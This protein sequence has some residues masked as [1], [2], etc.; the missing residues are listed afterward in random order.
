M[1]LKTGKILTVGSMVLSIAFAFIALVGYEETDPLRM[2]FGGAAM[3]LMVLALVFLFTLCRCP[4]CGHRLT[5]GMLTLKV[6][7]NCKRDLETGLKEKPQNVQQ[8][9]KKKKKR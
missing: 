1:E 4:W 3:L 9:K 8:S 5:Q 6:C 7:P 2:Y